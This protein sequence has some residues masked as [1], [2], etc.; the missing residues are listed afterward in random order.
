MMLIRTGHGAQASDTEPELRH[1]SAPPLVQGAPPELPV[2]P[3]LEQTV[4]ARHEAGH[5]QR[6]I[7]RDLNLDRRK[8]KQMVDQVVVSHPL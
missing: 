6:A 4:R 8:V 7:A 3:T 1:Q 5:S 2:A